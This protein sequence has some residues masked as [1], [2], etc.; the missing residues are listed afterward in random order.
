MAIDY[1]QAQ[2]C[3]NQMIATQTEFDLA[4]YCRPSEVEKANRMAF[5]RRYAIDAEFSVV[6]VRRIDHG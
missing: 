5:D 2:M 1:N 6:D 3:I 4:M